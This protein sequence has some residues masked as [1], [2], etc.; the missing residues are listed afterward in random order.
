MA[1]GPRAGRSRNAPWLAV[2]AL[3][4]SG[5]VPAAAWLV[6][7]RLEQDNDFC[8]ACHLESEV[9]LHQ[10]VRRDFEARVAASL[11]GA[12]GAARVEG[13][14]DG[15]FRCIDCHGGE[16]FSGRLRVKVLAAKDGF[17]YAVGRFEE[18]TGMRWPLWDEDCAQCH[19]RFNE[20]AAAPWQSPRFHQLPVHNVELGV[21]C[22]ECH[23]VHETGAA[24]DAYFLHATHVRSQCA[25]CH[26]EFEEEEG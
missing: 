18:P 9:P 23:L 14:E 25:R 6:T 20:A 24:P 12:H 19:A 13:R 22:V 17:W 21:N 16:S 11:A 26:S 3:V 4:G 8:N 10:G 1:G 5:G 2:M 7:D 15:A